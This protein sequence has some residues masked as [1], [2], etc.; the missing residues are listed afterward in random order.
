M[1]N[2][3]VSTIVLIISGDSRMFVINLDTYKQ[4]L[5]ESSAQLK[6][7]RNRIQFAE[8]QRRKNYFFLVQGSQDSPEG[9]P[10]VCSCLCVALCISA[11]QTD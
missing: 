3:F 1:K 9:I 11:S 8:L 4:T 7:C 10:S 5:F 2:C 6:V